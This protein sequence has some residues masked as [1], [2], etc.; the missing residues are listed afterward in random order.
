MRNAQLDKYDALDRAVL[1]IGTDYPHGRILAPHR[2][3]RAQVLYGVGGVMDVTTRHGTWIVP[4][5]R[6]VLIPPD[7]EHAVTMW[8]VSTQSLYIE[9]AAAPWFPTSCTVVDVSPLLRELLAAATELPIDH[10]VRGR[11]ATLMTLMLYEIA[12]STS[13]PL[14]LPVPA[15]P[16]LRT[17]CEMF[18]RN[19][20][21]R[22]APRWWAQALDVS[23]RTVHRMFRHEMSMSVSQWQRRACVLYAIRRLV[24]G[25]SVS[26]VAV[27]LGYATPSAFSTMFHRVTGSAPAS[28]RS[29]RH[30]PAPDQ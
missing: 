3:R 18:L 12:R 19:P 25:D 1:A 30:T 21:I 17:Q 28:F 20:N 26:T 11:D 14:E 16:A 9:P 15:D 24:A 10:A 29:G 8:G 2:H 23:E 13:L 4:P 5:Q 7:T 22:T 27:D 6:A